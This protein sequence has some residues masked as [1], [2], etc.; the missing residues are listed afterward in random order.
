MIESR[1]DSGGGDVERSAV[2]IK[3]WGFERRTLL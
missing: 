1:R 3:G 2:E